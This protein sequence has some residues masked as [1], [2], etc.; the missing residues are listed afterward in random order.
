MSY[1]EYQK[2]EDTLCVL[3]ALRHDIWIIKFLHFNSV[4]TTNKP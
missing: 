1:S 3:T 2:L 4:Y